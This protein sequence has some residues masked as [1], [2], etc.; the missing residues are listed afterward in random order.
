M[1]DDIMPLPKASPKKRCCVHAKPPN[2][3]Y[4]SPESMLFIQ[5][6]DKDKDEDF[7]TD[8]I[9]KKKCINIPNVVQSPTHFVLFFTE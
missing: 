8:V 4:T 3:V 1:M 7:D 9:P 5:N 6:K 2:P